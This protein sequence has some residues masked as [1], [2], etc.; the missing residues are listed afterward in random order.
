MEGYFKAMGTMVLASTS[1][2]EPFRNTVRLTTE[3]RHSTFEPLP[4]LDTLQAAMHRE[5][6]GAPLPVPLPVAHVTAARWFEA[7]LGIG[8]LTPQHCDVFSKNLLYFSYGAMFYRPT[9]ANTQHAVDWPIGLVFSPELLTVMTTLYPFDTG[10]MAKNSH[11]DH[12]R[13]RL[14]PFKTRFRIKTSKAQNVAPRLVKLLYTTNRR[15]VVGTVAPNGHRR[16]PI[17]LLTSY[18]KDDMTPHVDH[19]QRTIEC[20]TDAAVALG[21]HLEW[22]GVPMRAVDRISRE[23]YQWTKPRMPLVYPYLPTRNYNPAEI[24][25]EM[26][27]RSQADLVKRFL[28][29]E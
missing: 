3:C 15:Y 10:A 12:W 14:A 2:A 18:L 20:I 11:F 21:Q 13:R 6:I 25:R 29:L 17:P 19:R 28:D 27:A 7:I 1:G 26:H 8:K 22:V 4:A 24:T 23:L 16:A 5:R 9:R